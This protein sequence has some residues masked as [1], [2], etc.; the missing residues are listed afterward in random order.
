M[1]GSNLLTRS[2]HDVL[3]SYLWGEDDVFE[4]VYRTRTKHLH[5]EREI[6]G[7]RMRRRERRRAGD[8][9]RKGERKGGR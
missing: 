5:R 9:G 7:E 1:P 8:R 2:H 6:E 3:K 4:T